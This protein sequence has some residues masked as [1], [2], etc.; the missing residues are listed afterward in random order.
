MLKK[1]FIF[2]SKS[3]I[4]L[5]IGIFILSSCGKNENVER[6]SNTPVTEIP[7]QHVSEETST[8]FSETTF[9]KDENRTENKAEDI[10][11]HSEDGIDLL[12]ALHR[13]VSD[14]K[15]IYLTHGEPDLYIMP[16]GTDEHIPANIDNPEKMTVCNISLDTNGR[17]HLLV[18]GQDNETW[19]I[20]QL[21]ESS[22]VDRS[23]DISSYFETKH[24][25]LWFLVDKDGT[26]YLQ[27]A[28]G[29]NGIIVDSQGILQH[30]FTPEF[31]E[32]EW[33][34]EAAVGKDGRIYVV[35]SNSD[36]KIEIGKLDTKKC[37]LE[38]GNPAL[39][40]SGNETFS[41]MSGGTDTNL[42]LFSPYSGVWAYDGD[43]GVIENRV[44]LSELGFD[45]NGEVYPLTF[46]P[47]GRL[48]LLCETVIDKNGN[49]VNDID[50]ESSMDW[51]LKYIPA[52]K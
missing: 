22:Q 10:P 51:L 52:G 35:Y 48:I 23:I 25:P 4:A 18:A 30:R 2:K 37:F 24:I 19:F 49:P 5:F 33:I 6:E 47:D 16:I 15:K 20:W 40:F 28:I 36:E 1:Q 12:R 32:I 44:P 31:L 42:L 8:E 41:A 46:L 29:R 9:A 50:K 26:Y 34:Y 14:G 39:C 13:C 3:V 45:S 17:I 21:D 27:W 43:N 7:S 11:Y 38:K